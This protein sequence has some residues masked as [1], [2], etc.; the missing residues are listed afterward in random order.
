MLIQM[1]FQQYEQGLFSLTQLSSL[2]MSKAKVVLPTFCIPII[3]YAWDN[4]SDKYAL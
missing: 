4:L 1:L 3:K 2:A